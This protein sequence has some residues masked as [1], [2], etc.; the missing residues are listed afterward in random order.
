MQV[1]HGHHQRGQPTQTLKHIFLSRCPLLDSPI[2]HMPNIP[3]QST[4]P[5]CAGLD[6]RGE[7]LPGRP[8]KCAA[9]CAL[10]L[11]L[12]LPVATTT[13]TPATPTTPT[14]PA[15]I[16]AVVVA[17]ITATA[18]RRRGGEHARAVLVSK[19]AGVVRAVAAAAVGAAAAA[20]TPTAPAAA[21]P[22]AAGGGRVVDGLRL[23]MG[24]CV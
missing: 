18:P 12:G 7:Q 16:H 21:A 22:A 23:F 1:H 15:A 11:G 8:L 4:H 17:V 14:T 10:P 9:R 2:T 20:A 24:V 5:P 6:V 19:H 13:T 3:T